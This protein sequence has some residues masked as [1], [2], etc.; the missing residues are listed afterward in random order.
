MWGKIE[1]CNIISGRSVSSRPPLTHSRSTVSR[2]QSLG[3]SSNHKPGPT[4]GSERCF[5]F[6][7]PLFTTS[8]HSQL[9]ATSVQYDSHK[10]MR[11]TVGIDQVHPASD[12]PIRNIYMNITG[13]AEQ[14]QVFLKAYQEVK[15]R[16]HAPAAL[17]PVSTKQEDGWS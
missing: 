8:T 15:V 7:A 3:S 2:A 9:S 5:F 17:T 12:F 14:P 13:R 11:K 16:L 6:P 10:R 1:T 4:C